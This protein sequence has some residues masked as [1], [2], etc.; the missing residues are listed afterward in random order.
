VRSTPVRT[1]TVTSVPAVK[2]KR[3]A[4]PQIT[5]R[6]VYNQ[7]RVNQVINMFKRQN[8]D[9]SSTSGGDDASSASSISS[10]LSSAC[11]C[12]DYGG[13]TVTETYTNDPTVSLE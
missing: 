3:D 1:V 2:V 4:D 10:G 13:L 8:G 7:D 5:A 12:Q 9:P 11:S 6:A